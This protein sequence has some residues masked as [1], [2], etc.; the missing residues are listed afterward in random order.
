MAKFMVRASYTTEGLD[1]A[2][3]EGFASREQ[4]IKAITE[5]AGGTLEAFYFTY[6]DDDVLA[7][8]DGTEESA[9]ALSLAINRSGAVKLST[10]P[11]IT[12]EQMDAARGLLPDYR[13]PGA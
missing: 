5:A 2:I 8:I 3:S 9:I 7:I 6:G 13:S 1:G 11:L 12:P 10:T 4:A